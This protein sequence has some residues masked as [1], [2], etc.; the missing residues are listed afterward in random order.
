MGQ[1]RTPFAF[2]SSFD[3]SFSKLQKQ[4]QA[5]TQWLSCRAKSSPHC[6][7][8]LQLA[9]LLCCTV[10]RKNDTLPI[11]YMWS[12]ICKDLCLARELLEEESEEQTSSDRLRDHPHQCLALPV[13]WSWLGVSVEEKGDIHKSIKSPGIHSQLDVAGNGRLFLI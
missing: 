10:K 3:K 1:F 8:N 4:I 2:F 9:I 7:L 5:I 11:C 6:R 12:A 13:E